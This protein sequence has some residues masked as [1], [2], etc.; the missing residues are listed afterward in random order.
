VLL[1]AVAATILS[2]FFC[3]DESLPSAISLRASSHS[4]R[5]AASETS[6]KR[7]EGNHL[8]FVDETIA[9]PRQLASVWFDAKMQA[10]DKAILDYDQYTRLQPSGA[11][12]AGWPLLGPG[13]AARSQRGID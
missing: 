12:G 10:V 11:D 2:N 3:S 5:A 8:F 6:A 4:A 7:A 1:A 9:G 13:A